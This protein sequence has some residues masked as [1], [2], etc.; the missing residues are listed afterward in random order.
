MLSYLFWRI[1][2]WFKNRHVENTIQRLRN[3]IILLTLEEEE[4]IMI[5]ELN[6]AHGLMSMIP[7]GSITKLS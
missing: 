7:I 2:V 4:I 1:Q 3:V 6:K 5:M